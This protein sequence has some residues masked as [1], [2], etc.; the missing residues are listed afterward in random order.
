MEIKRG[1]SPG[2]TKRLKALIKKLERQTHQIQLVFAD[3]TY[4]W[5]KQQKVL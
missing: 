5:L 4:E 2:R 3:E 1:W